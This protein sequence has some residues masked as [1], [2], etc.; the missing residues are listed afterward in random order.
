MTK[1]EVRAKLDKQDGGLMKK[2]TLSVLLIG[3]VLL[4]GCATDPYGRTEALGCDRGT[5]YAAAAG[6]AVVGGLL[7]SVI[8]G[9]N[10]QL[11]TTGAGAAVGGVLGSRSRI[12]CNN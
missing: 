12:G 10:G 9:G 6:G 1:L 8:G 11:L 2:I 5:N 3:T 4:A 7:G